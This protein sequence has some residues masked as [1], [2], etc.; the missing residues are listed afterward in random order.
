MKFEDRQFAHLYQRQQHETGYPGML[1][2]FVMD[3]LKGCSSLI[4]IGAGSGFF[5]IPAAASGF[6]V[7]AVEPS[8]EMAVMMQKIYSETGPG[9]LTINLA[10]WEDW[11]G[12]VHDASICV[13]SFYPLIDKRLSVEKMLRYSQHRII[14]IRNSP[15]MKSVTGAVRA[16][17]GL[18]GTGDHNGL[19]VS[20][21]DELNVDFGITEITEQRDTIIKSLEDEAE[22]IIVRT[23]FNSELKPDVIEIIRKNSTY[24]S[25]R[26]IFHSVFC[27]NAYIF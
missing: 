12:P 14:I 11:S 5:A 8:E 7:T 16:E 15:K 9:S 6:S 17:L 22:S 13:H 2:P 25:G 21:L 3:Q 1:L 4:D 27:D 10:K 23:G 26:F 19:L 20:I 24:S 18:I